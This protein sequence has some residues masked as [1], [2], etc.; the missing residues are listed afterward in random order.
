M[1]IKDYFEGKNRKYYNILFCLAK[2]NE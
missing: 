1:K 2:G